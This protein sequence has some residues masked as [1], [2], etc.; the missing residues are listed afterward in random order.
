MEHIFDTDTNTVFNISQ[1]LFDIIKDDMNMD[2]T[3]NFQFM[4]YFFDENDNIPSEKKTFLR[5]LLMGLTSYYPI[6]KSSITDMPQ[7][8]EAPVLDQYKDYII[9]ENINIVPCVQS[10]RQWR[11]YEK[12]YKLDKLKTLK[13]LRKGGLYDNNNSDFNIRN[14]QNCNIVFENDDFRIKKDANK[15]KEM[16]DFMAG[17]N[18]LLKENIKQYSPK[19][20]KILENIGKFISNGNP[21]GKVMYYS[22]FR[23]DGGSEIFEEILKANGYTKFDYQKDDI[24]TMDKKLR[25]TFISGLESANER[26]VNKNTF[27]DIKNINGEYI[28]IILNFICW[29]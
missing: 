7:I 10:S 24:E 11:Q 14:R 13:R 6:G 5:R 8:V 12:T 23:G 2:L 26:K 17:N 9:S 29:C 15:K 21:T 28:Q 18:N 20:F 25:Y 16:Y 27:N 19:F 22:D 3:D 4:D 1:N